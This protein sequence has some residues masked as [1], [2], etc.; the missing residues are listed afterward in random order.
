M[1]KGQGQAGS[2]AQLSCLAFRLIL[3]PRGWSVGVPWEGPRGEIGGK[4]CE[5][6]ALRYYSHLPRRKKQASPGPL[7]EPTIPF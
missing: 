6:R 3:G 1:R 5:A 2:Q 7:L 4:Q